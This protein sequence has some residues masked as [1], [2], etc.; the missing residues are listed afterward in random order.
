MTYSKYFTNSLLAY[1]YSPSIILCWTLLIWKSSLLALF[2][3][4][5]A[6]A[7]G[8][9]PVEKYIILDLWAR[10][11][12][13]II[14]FGL[15]SLSCVLHTGFLLFFVNQI[16]LEFAVIALI[17]TRILA[18]KVL[19]CIPERLWTFLG[20]QYSSLWGSW[21]VVKHNFLETK[22]DKPSEFSLKRSLLNYNSMWL[23]EF[24]SGGF[25][26]RLNFII[27]LT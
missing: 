2:S 4:C 19:Y 5:S 15:V 21:N 10:F 18:S 25:K 16:G 9:Y 8:Y 26:N 12:Y 11:T 27:S 17:N 14:R 23:R 24:S 7:L 3:V 13:K 22:S 6:L 20:S 1:R